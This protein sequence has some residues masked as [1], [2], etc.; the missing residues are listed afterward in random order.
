MRQGV[1]QGIIPSPT[2]EGDMKAAV[3]VL[4]NG[5]PNRPPSSQIDKVQLFALPH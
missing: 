1:L 5:T 4:G 3:H 2:K